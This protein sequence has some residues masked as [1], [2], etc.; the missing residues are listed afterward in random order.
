MLYETAGNNDSSFRSGTSPQVSPGLTVSATAA[1]AALNRS[2]RD[3]F[4]HTACAS[5]ALYVRL[6]A[7]DRHACRRAR[8]SCNVGRLLAVCR[9]LSLQGVSML[10]AD[11]PQCVHVVVAGMI[12]HG[13]D[14]MKIGPVVTVLQHLYPTIYCTASC[15]TGQAV[16]Q[17]QLVFHNAAHSSTTSGASSSSL[18]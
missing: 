8:D 3:G 13:H 12:Y 10:A 11:R 17:L 2:R 6:R 14:V 15:L 5:S 4:E 1:T 18:C 16:L 7:L 9:P